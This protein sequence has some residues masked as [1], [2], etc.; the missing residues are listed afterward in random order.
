[1]FKA[2][3]AAKGRVGDSPE[4]SRSWREGWRDLPQV[5]HQGADLLWL[6]IQ[7]CRHGGVAAC[8]DKKSNVSTWATLTATRT[9][10]ARRVGLEADQ[11]GALHSD[12]GKITSNFFTLGS[13]RIGQLWESIAVPGLRVLARRLAHRILSAGITEDQP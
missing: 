6:E 3:Y 9:S 5:R 11:H 8:T 2:R 12:D 1:M 4:G 13:T 10:G 7:V